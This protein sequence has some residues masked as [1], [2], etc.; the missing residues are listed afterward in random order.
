MA[1]LTYQK[2]DAGLPEQQAA[3]FSRQARQ[4][5]LAAQDQA[6]S[7]EAT[8]ATNYDAAVAKHNG[9]TKKGY[10]V[11]SAASLENDSAFQSQLQAMIAKYPGMTKD[12]VYNVISGESG[13]D[14]SN[15]NPTSGAAGLFQF[16]RKTARGLGYTTEQ[17]AQMSSSDQLGVWDKYLSQNGYRGGKLGIMQAAPKYAN[18]SDDTVVYDPS[19]GGFSKLAWE[20]NPVWRGPDGKITVGSINKYYG[21]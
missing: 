15:V 17:I 5:M 13:F 14:P 12:Q 20:Q 11:T 2:V 16:V 7:I 1:V 21:Y 10:D 6:Q 8:S 9:L 4:M 19:Q 18:A 3:D